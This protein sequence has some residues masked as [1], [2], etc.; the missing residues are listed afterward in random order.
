MIGKNKKGAF[1]DNPNKLDMNIIQLVKTLKE[2]SVKNP[3][4]M[5]MLINHVNTD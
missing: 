1:R 2:E 5:H 3:F 4:K